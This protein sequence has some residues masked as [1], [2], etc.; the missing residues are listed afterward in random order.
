MPQKF[1][2][3]DLQTIKKKFFSATPACGASYLPGALGF[4][5][6]VPAPLA[7]KGQVQLAATSSRQAVSSLWRICRVYRRRLEQVADKLETSRV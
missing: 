2:A 4:R 3:T 1:Y 5:P 6:P 7:A